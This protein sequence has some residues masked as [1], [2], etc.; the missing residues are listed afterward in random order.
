MDSQEKLTYRQAERALYCAAEWNG[1]GQFTS[2]Q[3][4]EA[5]RMAG[6]ALREK[7]ERECNNAVKEYGSH[8][9]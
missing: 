9:I 5:I 7:A 1:S 3:L 6:E 2:D 8:D 4:K